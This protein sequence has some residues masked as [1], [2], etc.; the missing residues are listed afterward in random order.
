MKVLKK[1]IKRLLITIIILVFIVPGML[2]I[3][4]YFYGD[5]VKKIVVNEINKKLNIEVSVTDIQ[6]S[7][8]ENFPYASIKFSEIQT[9]EKITGNSNPLLK[10]GNLSFLFNVY[11]IVTSDY[12]IEK[13]LL[14]DA[15]LNIIIREDGSTNFDV[16]RKSDSSRHTGV[17]ID[18]Q[19]VVFRNVHVSY[20]NYPS[21][22]EYLFRAEFGTLKGKFTES[23]YSLNI[24]G[25]LFSTHIKSGKTVFLKEKKVA[26]DMQ[27][28]VDREKNNYNIKKGKLNVA[29]LS[30]YITGL[31]KSGSSSKYLDLKII[32]DKSEINS[33]IGIIPDE[34]KEPIKD[35]SLSGELYFRAD[36]KGDFTG[37][38][39]PLIIFNF[40]L[41]NGR[42]NHA[43]TGKTLNNVSLNGSFVNGKSKSK[44]S[45]AL[46]LDNFAA[47]LSSGYINGNMS[48]TNFE[49]PEIYV[50]LKSSLELKGIDEIARIDT[51]QSISG[52]LDINISFKNKLKSF[53]K[54]TVHDFISSRTSGS[55]KISNLN[56]ELKNSHLKYKDFNGSFKFNNKDLII[57]K[58]SGKV[59]GSDFN[60]KGNFKNIL[61]YVFLPG[62][63]ID[64]KADFF[65]SYLDF[66]E[67]LKYRITKTDTIYRL[68]FSERLNFD[69]NVDIKKMKFKKFKAQNI[70]GRIS[71]KDRKLFVENG[72][73]NSMDGKTYIS[74][75][76]DGRN[77]NKFWLNCEA[78]FQNVDINELF[79]EFDNFGQDNITSNHLRGRVTAKVF[80]KS[81]VSSNLKV[82]PKSVYTLAD[83]VISD[84]ELVNYMPLYKLSKYIKLEELQHI[85]FSILKNQVEI[86]DEVV[87]IPEMEIK[88]S[89]VNLKFYGKHTFRNDIDYHIWI[90]LSDLMW[91]EKRQSEEI[92]GIII[93]DDG[94]G[95]T[96]IPVKMTGNANDPDIKYD[97][98]AVR[99]KISSD[100]KKEKETIKKVFRDEFKWLH[101]KDEE[102]QDD[103]IVIIENQQKDFII[104]WDEEN[105]TIK[106][107]AD[108]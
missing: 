9:K 23:D 34:F 25:E 18:L 67:L 41:E 88:S 97:T 28:D 60:M 27:I 75:I 42:F 14:K 63:K 39:L 78:D 105:D 91:K 108:I 55:M 7:I 21:E 58:F 17:K 92:E 104:I 73:L 76:I 49:Q 81:S 50:V 5:E 74:G 89:S 11:D 62:E 100:L 65:S 40:N 96:S 106:S 36:I 77:Q 54:F 3:A 71:M 32:A 61:S 90:L 57:D 82:D 51:L 48:I 107:K 68:R 19:K 93:E 16:F 79:Y 38:K 52:R 37:N 35:Y 83:L 12:K 13:I 70:T 59:S 102:K 6:F 43:A 53:R 45:F 2:I 24:S 85:R 64:I 1:Y 94:L 56:F 101:K 22:Q 10:A 103:S 95:R 72:S 15:F 47:E 30:F 8:F 31:V 87:Y 99:K 29:G 46:K 69:L 44:K 80:Y 26:I 33:F 66:D 86:K 84:G 4:G 20:I 98:K